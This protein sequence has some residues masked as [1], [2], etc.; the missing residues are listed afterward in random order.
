MEIPAKEGFIGLQCTVDVDSLSQNLTPKNPRF[1]FYILLPEN[2]VTCQSQAVHPSFQTLS[3]RDLATD[4][5]LSYSIVLR[6]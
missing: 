5:K 6:S 3:R 1:H 2:Q 4:H